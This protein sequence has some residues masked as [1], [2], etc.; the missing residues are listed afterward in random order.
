[1]RQ[2]DWIRDQSPRDVRIGILFEVPHTTCDRADCFDRE[3]YGNKLGMSH[4]RALTEK[5]NDCAV[6][7]T[8]HN[9]PNTFVCV[10]RNKVDS[11]RGHHNV[12]HNCNECLCKNPVWRVGLDIPKIATKQR[13]GRCNNTGRTGWG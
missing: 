3:M 6:E 1:M 8:K 11:S 4:T 5:T 7:E 12:V 9:T 10:D 13:I 2:K